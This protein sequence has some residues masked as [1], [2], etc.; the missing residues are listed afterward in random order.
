MNKCTLA[1]DEQS[2]G[3]P[4]ADDHN[5]SQTSDEGD[6]A[7]ECQQSNACTVSNECNQSV[8]Q[9][10]QS[11]YNQSDIQNEFSIPSSSEHHDQLQP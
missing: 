4:I 10:H 7:D 11:V 2:S 1:S 6:H 9:A 3:L 5:D 8:E